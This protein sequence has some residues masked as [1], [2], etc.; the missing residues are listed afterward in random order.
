MY[1]RFSLNELPISNVIV[2][3]DFS[4]L[5]NELGTAEIIF[6]RGFYSNN[7]RTERPLFLF[8]SGAENK[9]E[10]IVLGKMIDF[11]GSL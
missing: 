6:K 11:G 10:V 8:F 9:N 7:E 1:K 3:R 2:G 5:K 4:F